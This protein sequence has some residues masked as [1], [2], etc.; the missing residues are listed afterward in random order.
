MKM[1]RVYGK[2]KTDKRFKPMDMLNSKFVSNL[3][4]ASMFP[5][6]HFD[7]LQRAVCFMNKHN[8]RLEFKIESVI[9]SKY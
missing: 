7:S 3:I 5:E 1:Y 9:E 4:Y 2:K 6:S 8:P